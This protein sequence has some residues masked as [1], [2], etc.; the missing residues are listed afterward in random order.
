[1]SGW[2]KIIVA[3]LVILNLAVAGVIAY[4]MQ[5]TSDASQMMNNVREKIDRKSALRTD[6]EPD[7]NNAEPFSILLLGV[8]TGDLGRTDQ[9][10]SDT[11]MVVTVNPQQKKSTIISL[12]RDIL[13]KIVGYGENDKL[14]HAYAYGGVKMS[15]N[16]IENLLDIPIDHYVTI[17]MRGLKDLVNAVGGIEVD[18]KRTF[19]LDGIKVKKGKQTLYGKKALAYARMRYEDPEGDVGRQKR[20]RE[21]VTKILKKVMSVNGV[22]NHKKILK[23]VEKNMKTD[24]SW[25]N[26]VDIGTNYLPAFDKI[27]QKQLAGKNDMSQGVYYQILGKHELLEVQ[28][29]LKKQ[30]ELPTKKKLPNLKDD[31]ADLLFYDDS[32]KRLTEDTSQYAPGYDHSE[33]YDEYGNFIGNQTNDDDENSSSGYQKSSQSQQSTDSSDY[34]DYGE[35]A[36]DS[37]NTYEG[38]NY[39]NN[40]YY[41]PNQGY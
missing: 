5:V 34:N 10:R 9:G 3:L 40:Q 26:M 6:G 13:T 17:N 7:I 38:Y 41:Q 19:T 35:P 39:E 8:D 29:T 36:V 11:M 20:Q 2:K 14:N 4:A 33:N 22:S 12:D 25:D 21:V 32:D 1:M 37:N 31:D 16:T 30:L 24:L 23:A 18:N 15:M 28:N 27:N